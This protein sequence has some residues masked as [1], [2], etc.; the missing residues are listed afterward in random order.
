L[1]MAIRNTKNMYE[2]SPIHVDK[3]NLLCNLSV[4]K[5]IYIF[6]NKPIL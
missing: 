3:W 4:I 1:K 2:Q 5:L 6:I